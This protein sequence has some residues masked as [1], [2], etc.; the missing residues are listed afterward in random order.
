LNDLLDEQKEE[1][2]VYFQ[3]KKS[4]FKTTYI[5]K[6]TADFSVDESESSSMDMSAEEYANLINQSGA[7]FI[8]DIKLPVKSDS[9]NAT[10]LSDDGKTLT[11]QLKYGK[12]NNINYQFSFINS[13]VYII[14]VA[15]VL[16]ILVAIICLLKKR[17]NNNLSPSINNENVSSNIDTNVNNSVNNFILNETPSLSQQDVNSGNMFIQNE[18]EVVLEQPSLEHQPPII[19]IVD[20]QNNEQ[21]QENKDNN[22]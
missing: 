7:E 19:P 10:S 21:T 12:L 3:K 1:I 17:K 5:A 13:Y 14:A 22:I 20:N 4:L 9:N 18:S 15:L 16:V 8:Y 11:W 6:F 2:K